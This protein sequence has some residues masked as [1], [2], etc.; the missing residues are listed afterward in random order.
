MTMSKLP[1]IDL[2]TGWPSYTLLPASR[3]LEASQR[4]L[5]DPDLSASAL[6]YGPDPGCKAIR[7]A[8][9]KWIGD[10]YSTPWTVPSRI[11]I[12]GGASQGLASILQVFTD[13][14]YTKNIFMIAPTY[15][16]ACRVFEDHGFAGRLKA[17]PEDIEGIDIDY[18]EKCLS[19]EEVTN[20]GK[21][22]EP[23]KKIYK[24][25]IYTVPTFSNPSG[26]T[27]T[28]HRRRQLVRLA[29]RHDALIIADD[30]YDQLQWP[31][32][33]QHQ[34]VLPRL[35]DIDHE[36]DDGPGGATADGFGNAISN[37]SFSKIL[38]PGC[39]TGWVEGTEKFI[40]GLSKCGSAVSGGA[41][42]QLTATVI[43][44]LLHRG[45]LTDH[46]NNYL[47]PGLERRYRL[48]MDA[49]HQYLEP[50]GARVKG[51]PPLNQSSKAAGDGGG[52]FLWIE[53]PSPLTS[54]EFAVRAMDL[55]GVSV[56]QGSLFEVYGDEMSMKCDREIRI[57]FAWE[58]ESLLTEG[59][60]RLRYVISDMLRQH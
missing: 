19:M 21:S 36:L 24:Y 2:F 38:A 28:T 41:P 10:F 4:V 39:R 13:P 30:V 44:D 17:V 48:V 3:L 55:A 26:K 58:D 56:A 18:L 16:L 31:R 27:M 60:Q 12:S 32:K 59:I 23:W 37:G 15:H 50:L 53:L 54:A 43:A 34:D 14:S 49:I 25:V 5:R 22:L 35:V 51:I 11:C 40:Y 42:S 6:Q 29:R 47:I 46:M 7:E 1:I 57:C 52:Y 45:D 9:A 33:R 20:S 8:I